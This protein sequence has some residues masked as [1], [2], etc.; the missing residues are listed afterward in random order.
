[1]TRRLTD[2]GGFT[3]VELLVAMLIGL[4]VMFATLVV[5]DGSWRVQSRTAD[6]IDSTDR[7]RLGM[8]RITQQL[9]ARVCV[10]ATTDAT[11]L[12]P[13][14][15]IVTAT[16]NQIEFY[17]SVTSDTAPRLVT[18]RRRITYR[19]A[20]RDILL[21]TWRA[22]A[23]PP[24]RPPANTTT[25][26]ATKILAAEVLPVTTGTAPLPPIFAYYAFQGTPP[27]VR[28]ATLKKTPPLTQSDLDSVALVKVD[29]IADGK[30]AGVGAEFQN[31]SLTRSPTTCL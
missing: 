29:F 27:A 2:E 7:G 4:V 23:A 17:A 31:D 9:D 15:S 26:T 5:M 14:G 1:V 16:D 20:T 3:L 12:P 21:E 28:L 13:A 18:E 19:P 30:R 8:D 10:P 6:T 22:T 25:P 11:P 24:V